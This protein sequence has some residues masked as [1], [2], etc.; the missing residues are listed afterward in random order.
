[1]R[2]QYRSGVLSA[3]FLLVACGEVSAPN[4]P[5]PYESRLF[6]NYDNNGTPAVDSLRFH[7]PASSMPVSYW[8]QDSLNA[9]GH[10]QAAIQ[11]W[12][13]AF[14][15]R[16]WDARLV[17]DSNSADVIV[18][19]MQAPPKPAPALLRFFS[20]RP[21]CEGVT[22]IDTVA[23]RRQLRLPLR[24]YLNPRLPG[25]PSLGLCMGL[26]AV[27]EMGHSMG[28]FQHTTDP[29]DIMFT[30]PVATEL[31]DRDISTIEALYHRASDMVPVRP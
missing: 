25:D 2:I 7:W 17:T 30:D 10:V 12:K 23:T 31:S 18:R 8:V 24:I 26:T 9:P 13:E 5:V 11:T 28:L 22:D 1:M 14:L 4:R 6:I 16:E 15:Y 20:L 19:V 21:E 27:H 3:V 29:A